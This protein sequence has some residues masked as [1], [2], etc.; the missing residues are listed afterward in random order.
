MKEGHEEEEEGGGGGWLEQGRNIKE[1]ALHLKPIQSLVVH[2]KPLVFVLSSPQP[3]LWQ[4]HTDKLAPNVRR[5]F[6]VSKGS[7]VEFEAGNFSQSCKVVTETLPQDNEPLLAWAKRKYRAVTSFT[8]IKLAQDVYIKVGEDPFFSD[9]CKIDNKFLSLNYLAGYLQPQPSSGCVLSDPSQER[10]VHIIQLQAPN[11]SSAFQVDVIVDIGPLEAD[12]PVQRDLLLL[13]KCE[14]SVNWVIQAHGVTGKLT[15]LSSDSVS[16]GAEVE[17]LLQVTVAKQ[18]LPSGPQA[19]IKW[20]EEKGFSPSALPPELAILRDFNPQQDPGSA[21]PQPGLPFF[22]RPQY[23][24]LPQDEPPVGPHPEEQQGRLELGLEV[25]INQ[26]EPEDGSGWLGF[27]EDMES[28]DSS[29]TGDAEG[30]DRAMLLDQMDSK[31]APILSPMPWSPSV[32]FSMTLF[33]SDLFTNPVTQGFHTISQNTSVFVEVTANSADRQLGF[34]IQSCFVTPNPVSSLA[35]DYAL[36]ENVC[37]KDESV[38][39]YPPPADVLV[40]HG[41]ADRK[42]FGFTFRSKFSAPQLF[43]HCQMAPSPSIRIIPQTSPETHIMYVLDTP[44]VVGIAFA[45]FVIGALLTG[46]LWFIYSHTGE[47]A[48]RQQVAKSPPASENSSATHSMGSTQSTPCS[49]SSTA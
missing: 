37:P 47:T 43:L 35:S 10:Q 13:L 29:F 4:L 14:K 9:T 34:M 16:L 48:G 26:S 20:A 41:Q 40:P 12:R 39:Y 8:E 23:L 33:T 6:H 30:F 5:I 36:I 21:P 24:P 46:A 49:S 2:S 11:S 25:L 45:A 32:S 1:V 38:R 22:F 44:T 27:E 19:L 31:P 15:I 3:I 18:D 17:Q 42:R 28:G 7:D